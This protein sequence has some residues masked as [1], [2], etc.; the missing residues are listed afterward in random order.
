MST[1]RKCRKCGKDLEGLNDDKILL[2]PAC[3]G[4][5]E[6]YAATAAGAVVS[7]A[8]VVL[9]AAKIVTKC[10][11]KIVSVASKVIRK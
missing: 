8:A 3:R 1:H 5:L 6:G 9:T 2:C 10:G 11:P 7:V 4:V